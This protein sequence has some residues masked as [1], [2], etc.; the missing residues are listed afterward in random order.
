MKLSTLLKSAAALSLVAGVAS[1]E[2]HLRIQTHYAPESVSGKLAGQ[3]V[4]DIQTMSNGEITIEMFYSSSVVATVEAFDAAANG[5]LDCDMT[6]GAYQTGKNPAFQ[7]VGDIMGGYNTPYQQLSWLYHGGGYEAA[8]SLYNQFGMQ[9]IGWWVYGQESFASTKPIAS[10]ADFKDWKFRS[11]PGLETE[12]FAEL[13]AKPIVMD[14]TEV[15]TALETGIIDGAD[16]SGIANNKSMGL[17][18]IAKFANYPGFHSMPSDH[19]A[20]NKAV[21]DGMPEHHRRIVDT[22][23]QK[24][25]LQTALTFEKA[26]AEAVAALK[27]DGVTINTWNDAD[28]ASFRAAAQKAWDG[29]AAKTPEAAALVASHR[30]YLGQLGLIAK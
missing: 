23:M 27:A 30:E 12:I 10:P 6:G 24:L 8:Q 4:D 25:A 26:N 5:I 17:Y 19:L 29:W 18:D 22:A 21:W 2:T 3:F 7:F 9:L 20:C 1:A 11:P 28:L 14:F 15:F 13:G 16:A